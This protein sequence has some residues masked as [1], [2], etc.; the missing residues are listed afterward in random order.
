MIVQKFGGTSVKS[1]ARIKNV[2]GIVARAA[3]EGPVV[4]V[5]SAMSG[6]TD[7][8]LGTQGRIAKASESEARER[9]LPEPF[10]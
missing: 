1:L 3:R 5:V 8:L 6:E 2:A 4:V 10:E 7:R 9:S